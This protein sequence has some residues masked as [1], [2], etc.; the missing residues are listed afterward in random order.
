MI[1][2]KIKK[3]IRLYNQN[4]NKKE[5]FQ[6]VLWSSKKSMDNRMKFF[7]KKIDKLEFKSWIDIGC[8]TGR[9]FELIKK[10]KFKQ[11]KIYGIDINK[12]LIK[13]CKKKKFKF[14][15]TFLCKNILNYK[16]KKFDLVSSLGVMQNSGLGLEEFINSIFNLTQYESYIYINFKTHKWKKLKNNCK[17]K[18]IFK[19][20]RYDPIDVEKKLIKKFKLIESGGFDYKNQKKTNFHKT[21]EYFILAQRIK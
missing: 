13:Y 20:N 18:D 12:K 5:E 8:G 10:N 1:K 3:V 4:F 21:G 14:K 17:E 2:S 19:I 15:I 9:L 16:T 6:K 7:I 11:I